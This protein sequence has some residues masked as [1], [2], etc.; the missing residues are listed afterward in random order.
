MGNDDA[1]RDSDGKL[2]IDSQGKKLVRRGDGALYHLKV[3]VSLNEYV[4]QLPVGHR[5][6]LEYNRLVAT[7]ALMPEGL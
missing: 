1:A 2:L 3:E 7:A 5:A 4:Q 6:R